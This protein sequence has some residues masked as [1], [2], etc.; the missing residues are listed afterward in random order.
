MKDLVSIIMPV[1]NNEKYIKES[2]ESILNQTYDNIELLIL[3]DGS[4]DRS[5]S[6]I[7]E[8]ALENKNIRL[9]SRMNKGV[10]NSISELIEYANGEYIAR[11]DGDDISY[12]NRIETQIKYLK[13]NGLYLV[14]S[15]VDIEITDYKSENDKYMCEKIFNFKLDKDHQCLK[16]LN[17]NRIC[18]GTFLCKANL[19]KKISYN[20]D[21]KTSEDLDFIFEVIKQ[22][23]KIGII[24]RKLYLNR[25]NSNFI[26][27]QK[28]LDEKYNKEILLSKIKF[29]KD[30]IL[31]REILIIGK[32]K[33][34]NQLFEL[35][36]RD[37]KFKVKEIID[38]IDN[39]E[40]EYIFIMDRYNNENIEHKLIT[41]GKKNL[42][43]FISL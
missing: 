29:L 6:I 2:I 19:F 14:G 8:Y 37:S 32:N 3:N 35:L 4:T 38:S 30:R 15:Y 20:V 21:L 13:D 33:Y 1:C 7:E 28:C 43:D 9:I 34:G 11:M 18:H 41:M 16:I 26:H 42:Y 25:V 39:F 10:S 12:P 5:L 36:N 23:Y 40:D 27:E 22:D 17:G 31:N 24:D